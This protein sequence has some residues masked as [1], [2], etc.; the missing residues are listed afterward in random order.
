RAAPEGARGRAARAAAR[1]SRGRPRRRGRVRSRVGFA[2]QPDLEAAAE[3]RLALHLDP[4]AVLLDDPVRNREA[5][6]RALADGLGGE[7][8][9]EDRREPVGGGALALVVAR[10]HGG[11]APRPPPPALAARPRPRP[12]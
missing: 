9:V 3:A 5:E 1:P 2:R 8:G 6:P 11:G 7:E 10:E 12:G 4:A